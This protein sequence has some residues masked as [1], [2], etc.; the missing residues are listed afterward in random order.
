VL[1]L[2]G[3]LAATGGFLAAEGERSFSGVSIDSRSVQAGEIFFALKGE[4]HDGHDYLMPALQQAAGAVVSRSCRPL[5]PTRYKE[6][7]LVAVD[8]TIAALQQW[9]AYC[10]KEFAGQV[11]AIAGSNGKTTTKEM[12]ASVLSMCRRTHKTAGNLNNHI[13]LPLSL[14][15][16]PD[17][18]EV[19]V[20]EMG[21]NQ[22]GDVAHL[23]AIARPDVGVIT[24]IGLE[25]LL[26]F[27]S[28]E[29]VRD[30]ELEL[31]PYVHTVIV[32]ADDPFLMSGVIERFR[33]KIISFGV[34]ADNADIRA[35][36]IETTDRGVRFMLKKD[37]ASAQVQL[38]VAGRFNIANAAAAAGVGHAFGMTVDDI[39]AGLSLFRG[40]RMRFSVIESGGS[41]I[42]ADVYNANPSSMEAAVLELEQLSRSGAEGKRRRTIAVLGDMLELGEREAELHAALGTFLKKQGV[43]LFVG[44]GRLMHSAVTAFGRGAHTVADTGAAADFLRPV[45]TAGDVILIKGS[46]GMKME[47]LCELLGLPVVAER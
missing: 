17:D 34:S 45:L 11:V 23:C 36:H 22:P 30:A 35:A 2:D 42:L 1:T 10:R 8:D 38:Q 33:G 12:T 41:T 13:G 37:G 18:A 29:K 26:G 6:K 47:R 21:T 9:A 46:R 14:L 24:N 44:V 28:L 25:H 31:L 39:A 5:D 15:R 20:V 19:I 3:L 4:R 7:T 27:G 43:D 32:N 16:T 40:V